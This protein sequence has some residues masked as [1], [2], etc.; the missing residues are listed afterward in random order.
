MF[1]TRL[2]PFCFLLLLVT[3]GTLP[4]VTK[5][6]PAEN[7]L[8]E[9]SHLR[10]GGLISYSERSLAN[11]IE[12]AADEVNG[13]GG[14]ARHPIELIIKN[15]QGRPDK[16]SEVVSKLI[17]EDRVDALIG[18]EESDVTLEAAR[19][20]QAAKIPLIASAAIDPD[21]TKVG[22]YIFRTCFIDPVQ[23]RA[24]AK[25]AVGRLKAKRAAILHDSESKDHPT[26]AYS[27][28]S[29]FT[30]LGGVIV[31]RQ[32]YNGG[33]IDFLSRLDAI[34]SAKPEVLYIPGN[35]TEVALIARQA[36]AIGI[37]KTTFIGG[38][39]WN[40]P[41]I[42]EIAG[43]SID[44]SYFTDH[45]SHTEPSLLNQEFVRKYLK[46]YGKVPDSFAAL[47]YDSLKILADS[48][49]R[50]KTPG[51]VALRD[52]IAQTKN[53]PGVTGAITFDSDRNARKRVVILQVR[54]RKFILQNHR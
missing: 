50:A 13:S 43:Q 26:L 29:E 22:D 35:Y 21:V 12:M 30:K 11:G 54:G 16:A 32:T 51:S 20:A 47:G 46:R 38:D 5:P 1:S 7:R 2:S 49:T 14:V 39:G 40:S 31:S 53:F 52:A 36:R 15:A 18:G 3:I 17:K 34:R 8:Q 27:F 42:W 24:M 48:I 41:K 37:T 6:T 19:L 4:A 28:E 45:Y 25:F 10:I 33:D 44:E 23:G 9:P